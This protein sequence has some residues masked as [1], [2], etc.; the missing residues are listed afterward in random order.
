MD[1]TAFNGPK[2]QFAEN[3]IRLYT[4][5]L[6]YEVVRNG[7]ILVSKTPI[8]LQIDG[9]TYGHESLLKTSTQTL[10]GTVKT[11][12]YKKAS[13][14][15]DATETLADFGPYAVRLIARAD[16]VAYR[17]ESKNGGTVENEIAGLTI[18]SPHARCWYN[19]TR[20]FGCEET[21]ADDAD[22][23]DLQGDTENFIYLPLAYRLDNQVVCV[24]ESE[25][26]NYPIWNLINPTPTENGIH[27]DAL[28]ERFPK[29]TAR[30]SSW[31]PNAAPQEKGGLKIII[32]EFEDYLTQLTPNSNL[33]WRVFMLADAPAKLCEADIVFALAHPQDPDTDFSWVKPGQVAWD[34]WNTFD[35]KGQAEGCTTAGYVRF[36]DFAAKNNVEYVIFDEGWSVGYDIWNNSPAVDTPYLINYANSKGVG[37]ILW[38]G[39]A[40]VVGQ[41]EKVAAYFSKLGAKGFKVDFMDRGDAEVA[42]FLEDFARACAN[43]HML[44]DYH[45]TYRPNGLHRRY[46]NVINYEGVHGLENM[47]W[48]G[49]DKDLSRQDVSCV[50]LR[51]SAGPMD[52]TPGAMN[53][54]KLGN[55]SE[56]RMNPGS[57]GTRV[58]QMA[59]MALYE[60]PLQMLADSPTN[61]EKNMECFAFMANV[62]TVWQQTIGISGCPECHAALARQAYDGSWYVSA[63][64]NRT[65]QTLDIPTHFLEKGVWNAEIF[66]DDPQSPDLPEKYLHTTQTITAGETLSFPLAEMGGL[67]IHFTK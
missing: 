17:F 33:P 21:V 30:I 61:Y 49:K 12:V 36:I 43:H 63:I 3:E 57:V 14:C 47:K 45:G 52:Y 60:A 32:Q 39:W 50:F 5:P 20:C 62:P 8:G 6:A 44:V 16:G 23:A 53:N 15:L 58:H 65:P 40:Q 41:E 18:P 35:N 11:P 66:Q 7:K 26:R 4:A 31:S 37:I 38:M 46:P 48:A 67:T 55:Y 13:I 28:F 24:S 64:T 27:L 29:K 1:A 2:A 10:T 25:I 59:L 51:M 56:D 54:F 19:R 42:T 34:W 22:A 9:T